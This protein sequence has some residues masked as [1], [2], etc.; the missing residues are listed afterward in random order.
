MYEQEDR[1]LL[2]CSSNLRF[3][4]DIQLVGQYLQELMMVYQLTSSPKLPY[5]AQKQFGLISLP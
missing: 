1:R 4:L 3:D 2:V 5:F